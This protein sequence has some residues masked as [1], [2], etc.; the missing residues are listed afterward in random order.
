MREQGQW[1]SLS[2]RCGVGSRMRLHSWAG[3]GV[4]TQCLVGCAGKSLPQRI[5]TAL[6]NSQSHES[7]FL[8]WKEEARP[9]CRLI[10]CF[11]LFLGAAISYSLLCY[12]P[13]LCTQRC[14][15]LLWHPCPHPRV[16]SLAAHAQAWFL[17]VPLNQAHRRHHP[18]PLSPCCVPGPVLGMA[19]ILAKHSFFWEDTFEHTG[20]Q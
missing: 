12:V 14:H 3:P 4:G 9:T 10:I 18:W 16:A 19:P 20:L 8:S 2:G 1:E 7:R 17:S 5:E 13:A 6:V 11:W 15:C